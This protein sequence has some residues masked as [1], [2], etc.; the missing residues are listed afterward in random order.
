MKVFWGWG[1]CWWF[2]V[3]GVVEGGGGWLEV[4]GS[5]RLGMVE[6]GLGWL[7]VGMGCLCTPI[8]FLSY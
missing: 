4:V 1:G 5:G 8:N 6:G 3:V 2:D 7:E